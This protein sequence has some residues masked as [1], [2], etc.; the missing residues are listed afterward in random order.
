MAMWGPLKGM[1]QSS[2]RAELAALVI[3]MHIEVPLHIG[4]DNKAVVDKATAL[5]EKARQIAKKGGKQP[6]RIMKRPWSLQN[7]GDLWANF[8]ETLMIR[9]PGSIWVTK[10][11]GHA[12]EVQVQQGQ[13]E[14]DDKKGND[15]ADRA[16]GEGVD[17]HVQG[18]REY[19]AWL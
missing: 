18:L 1:W 7:D 11:K 8:W 13:V 5:I 19:T 15:E 4:I 12:T 16:A 9:S 10:V 14:E 3:A 17:E 6:K 2:T